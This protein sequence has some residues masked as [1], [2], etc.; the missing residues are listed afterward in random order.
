LYDHG[1]VRCW[2]LNSLFV[3][4]ERVAEVRPFRTVSK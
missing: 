3:L 4:N 1:I 2:L